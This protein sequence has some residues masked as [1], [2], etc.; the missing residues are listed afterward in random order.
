MSRPRIPEP[1]RALA[2]AAAARGWQISHLGSGHLRWKSPDG[3][4]VVTASTPGDRRTALNER[5]RLRRAGL[6]E[7]SP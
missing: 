2:R 1:L 4:V 3:A 7:E 6:R 5:A